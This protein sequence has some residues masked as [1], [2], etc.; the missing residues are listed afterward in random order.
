M[1]QQAA[2]VQAACLLEEA[3]SQSF[4]QGSP[5]GSVCLRFPGASHYSR[6]ALIA[7]GAQVQLWW[8]DES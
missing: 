5:L 2:G 1:N 8:W 4:R 6:A 7:A 3:V